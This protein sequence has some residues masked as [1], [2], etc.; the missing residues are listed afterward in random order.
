MKSY[1]SFAAAALTALFTLA[2]VPAKLLEAWNVDA[3]HTEINFSV[4]H[5][6]TPV[7]GSFQDFEIDLQYDRTNPAASSVNVRIPVASIS[8]GNADRDKH[9]LS[10]DFFEADKHPYITFRSTSVRQNGPDGLI[11]EGAL[12]IKGVTQ[13]IELPLTLLGQQEIPAEM[14]PMLG[15]VKRVI[16]FEANTRIRR[17]DYGVGV[18]SWAATL[19]VGGNVDIRIAVEANQS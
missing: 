13:E 19:V 5:F 14:Q 15:G 16:G 7:S 8:T 9:L 11:A 1:R 2:A 12:T 3:A 4:N 6:F 18:G 17:Q 10:E